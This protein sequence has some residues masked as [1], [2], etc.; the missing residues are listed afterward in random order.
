MSPENSDVGQETVT[1]PEAEEP[2]KNDSRSSSSSSRSSNQNHDVPQSSTGTGQTKCSICQSMFRRPEHLKRHFRSH[3]KEKPFECA[4]CGRHFSR[5][6][7]LHRH[8]L[9]HHNAGMEGGKDRTHRITV[10]TFRACYKCAIARV[11]CSGG[12]PCARCESRSLE[13]QYP[14]ERR[15]KAKTRKET[16]PSFTN[17]DTSYD[18][19]SHLA[20]STWANGTDLRPSRN[21]EQSIP[22]PFHYQMTQFQLQMPISNAPNAVAS[23]LSANNNNIEPEN[24][25]LDETRTNGQA[26]GAEDNSTSLSLHD[27]TREVKKMRVPSVQNSTVGTQGLYSQIATSTEDMAEP[28]HRTEGLQSAKGSDGIATMPTVGSQ[29]VPMELIQP[30]LNQTTVPTINWLPQDLANA[31]NDRRHSINTYQKTSGILDTSLSQAPWYQSVIHGTESSSLVSE[32]VSQTPSGYTSLGGNTESPSQSSHLNRRV[33]NHSEDGAIPNSSSSRLNQDSWSLLCAASANASL[34]LQQADTRRQYL[35]PQFPKPRVHA[36][37]ENHYDHHHTLGPPTYERIRSA[38]IQLCCAES[39]LYPKFESDHLPDAETLSSFINLY[40]MHFQP[41]YPIFHTPTFDINECHWLVVLALSAIGC[42]FAGSQ[43][44]SEC[45]PVF[46]EFLRRAISV[47]EEKYYVD[48]A[49]VWLLQASVLNCV[50]ILYSCDER[51]RLLAL[52]TFGN[53]IGFVN[54]EKLLSRP[55]RPIQPLNGKTNEQHW[56]SWV[57]DEIRRRIGYLIWLL[58]CTI[59]YHFDRRPLLSLDESQATLPSHEALWTAKSLEAWKDVRGRMSDQKESSLY[60]AVLVMYIEKELVPDIGEFSQLLL[61]HALYHRMWEVGDYFRRPL[62]FWNP[63]SKKQS[64]HSALPS[65]SVW[66]PG[67]PS[68]SKWRNSACDCLDILHW[69]AGSTVARTAGLEHP[70]ILHLHLARIILLA[71]FREIRSLATSLAMEESRWCEREQT[72]EWHYILRWVKHDQYK[73]RLAV[74]HAGAM[75]RHARDFSSR[76]F[77]EPVAVFLAT[78][79]LWAYGACYTFLSDMTSRHEAS[80]GM[81]EKPLFIHLDRP[82]DDELAQ[83]F[84]REGQG[85]KAVLTGV[86]DICAPRG[87][88]ETLKAGCLILAGLSSW[89]ISK[90]FTAILGKL[91]EIT[92]KS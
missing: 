31:S 75:L 6:D 2:T 24:K 69:A 30:L 68:Y 47:E 64:R 60:D 78:L 46:H 1:R 65:G 79:V 54:R 61:I 57:E 55:D 80:H 22:P 70:T 91:S 4:Q 5:T 45:A 87:P 44:Q 12:S 16:Q 72:L 23:N 49:P 41:V 88:E 56:V 19:S 29:Q 52:N 27:S 38:F 71:P 32:N 13:C 33:R 35:F 10:K 48:R 34:Q 76:S 66:L 26:L 51:A 36:T 28:A 42:H 62:S 92:S 9:S 25:R 53:L 43:E 83:L 11:R 20:Q 8:E 3:T 17:D 81:P 15:S 84:V 40:F 63:T 14:T 74:V 67:I 86:G 85:M 77:H 18:Q 21:G 37:N 82:C 39:I 7:T 50:G 89:G 59:A 90:R 73:A 58:D